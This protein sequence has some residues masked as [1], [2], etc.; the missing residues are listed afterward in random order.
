MDYGWQ[1]SLASLDIASLFAGSKWETFLFYCWMY[2]SWLSVIFFQSYCREALLKNNFLFTKVSRN[3]SASQKSVWPRIHAR[4]QTCQYEGRH[5]AY[6]GGEA[7]CF[8]IS[9]LPLDTYSGAVWPTGI[10]Q[11]ISLWGYIPGAYIWN[12]WTRYVNIAFNFVMIEPLRWTREFGSWL[13]VWTGVN[14]I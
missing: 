5:T 8:D 6:R 4:G 3:N 11:D 14:H 9:S 7:E 12:S 2:I 13:P 10:L 1:E